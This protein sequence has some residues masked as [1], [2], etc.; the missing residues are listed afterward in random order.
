M[1]VGFGPTVPLPG[2]ISKGSRTE[3]PVEEPEEQARGSVRC[4]FRFWSMV[5]F[6]KGIYHGKWFSLVFL[7]WF[8]L[9]GVP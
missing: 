7:K 8:S 5:V 9:S 6:L 3:P 2:R 4:L 1:P